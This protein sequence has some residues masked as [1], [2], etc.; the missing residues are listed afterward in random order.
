[1]SGIR[2]IDRF[3]GALHRD[4]GQELIFESG[5][6][7]VIITGTRTELADGSKSRSIDNYWL[8]VFGDNE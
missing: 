3:V 6:P 8:K 2:P 7:G 5:G 1:M 4:Q